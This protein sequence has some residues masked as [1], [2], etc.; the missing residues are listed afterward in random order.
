MLPAWRVGNRAIEAEFH[1]SPPLSIQ[2]CCLTTHIIVS[3]QAACGNCLS[4]GGVTPIM[5]V[6]ECHNPHSG[7]WRCSM[8]VTALEIK[9]CSP[10]AQ[11]TTFGDVG[12]YEQLDGTVHFVVDP[13]HPSNAGITDLQLAPRDAHGLVRCWA[14]VRILKPAALQHGNHRLLL[15]IVNRG[16]P[17]VLT[18]FNSAVSRMEPGNGFLMH[19]GYTVIWCG[20]QDDVPA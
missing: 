4:P 7:L 10:F 11:G 13:D 6:T 3:D 1:A 15:D 18:N 12:P 5:C 9:T 16:N 20:W 14:D 17:T 2:A 19:Q 8:A